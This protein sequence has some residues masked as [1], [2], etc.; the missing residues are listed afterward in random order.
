M[1]SGS[2]KNRRRGLYFNFGLDDDTE[3]YF[4]DGVAFIIEVNGKVL[5]QKSI[6]KASG[7]QEDSLDLSKY[8]GKTV[9]LSFITDSIYWNVNDKAY[10]SN[11]KIL[12]KR[13]KVA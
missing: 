6:L 8:A 5:F 4:S 11:L 10:W 2:R 13:D 7:W 12:I 9:V 1:C 3:G